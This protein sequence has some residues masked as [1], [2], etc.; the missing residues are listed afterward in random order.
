MCSQAPACGRRFKVVAEQ[1]EIVISS[2]DPSYEATV[3]G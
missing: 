3:Y 1:F 2:M